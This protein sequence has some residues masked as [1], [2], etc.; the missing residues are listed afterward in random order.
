MG[1]HRH[2]SHPWRRLLG[3]AFAAVLLG[4]C[5][6]G[7]KPADRTDAPTGSAPT[8]LNAEAGALKTVAVGTRVTMDGTESAPLSGPGL[9]YEWAFTYTPGASRAALAGSDTSTPSFVPD[10]PGT[11]L[12]QLVVYKQGQASERDLV[13]IRAGTPGAVTASA[14]FDHTGITDTCVTCHNGST[15]TTKPPVHIPAS[16]QC[17]ACHATTAWVPVLTVDH[18]EVLGSCSSCHDGTLAAGKPANHPLTRLECNACH[19][20][21]SW[22]RVNTTNQTG[23][24]SG[25]PGALDDDTDEADDD[26]APPA[27]PGAPPPPPEIVQ[28]ANHDTLTEGCFGCHNNT[29][30]E[31]KPADHPPAP[32]TCELCH[33]PTDWEPATGTPPAPPGTPPATPPEPI[34]QPANHDQLTSGCFGCHNNTVTEG[35]PA[36]HIPSP[37]T[38]ESCHNPLAWTP[39]TPPG[40]PP[41][42][43]PPTTPPGSPPTPPGGGGPTPFVHLPIP[44]GTLCGTCH[45]GT[46]ATGKTPDHVVTTL[47][48]A[49]CHSTSAWVP[50]ALGGQQPPSSA[51][52]PAAGAGFDHA[53]V[54]ASQCASCHNGTTATGQSVNHISTTPRCASCHTTTRWTPVAFVDHNQVAGRCSGCHDGITATGKGANHPATTAE[55]N[56]CHYPVQWVPVRQ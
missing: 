54:S 17:E 2:Y 15:A 18:N 44:A 48:C 6:G 52:P 9:N 3:L 29:L 13:T 10:V 32:D 30:V 24:G 47:D 14:P 34:V 27:D 43:S 11:Y 41:P 53:G 46:I 56:Q 55:C 28:P 33:V 20:S 21:S 35:K 31:G 7:G 40:T 5:G 50:L 49:T 16:D 38:C 23:T 36:D 51:N 4:A 22:V 25:G 37:D 1:H 12:V 19:A 8:A 45:N 26:D 42:T 39:A